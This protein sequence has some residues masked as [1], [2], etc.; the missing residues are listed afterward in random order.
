MSDDHAAVI[1]ISD[2][3]IW[4]LVVSLLA[5]KNKTLIHVLASQKKNWWL[6]KKLAVGKKCK[7]LSTL[8]CHKFNL[9]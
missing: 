5:G 3:P 8:D 6:E 9:L 7:R 2:S 4:I 1:S